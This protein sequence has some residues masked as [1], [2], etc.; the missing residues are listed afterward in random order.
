MEA[1]NRGAADAGAPSIGFNVALA[2]EQPPNACSTPEL[3]FRFQNFAIRKLHLAM[4]A[5]ALV[6]FTG[7]FGTLDAMFE[8]LTLKQTGKTAPIPIV[9]FDES[10]W[11]SIVN[12]ERLAQEGMIAE[13]DRLWSFRVCQ[14]SAGRL[15]PACA[16]R[17]KA[18]RAVRFRGG[19]S[20]RPT[21]QPISPAPD[22]AARAEREGRSAEAWSAGCASGEEPYTIKILGTLRS[23]VP[24]QPHQSRSPPQMSML[25]CWHVREKD[26]SSRRACTNC[27]GCLSSAVSSRLAPCTA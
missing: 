5:N 2:R 8:I 22:I 24:V 17:F 16:L 13:G 18:H 4:R 1:A 21:V 12:F 23:H 19:L 11:R 10:Y 26:V 20:G 3:T 9:L 6:V 15:E 25:R 14:R 27:L 7:G